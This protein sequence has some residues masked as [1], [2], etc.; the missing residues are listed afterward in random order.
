[1]INELTPL[2]LDAIR[3]V[4]NIG[5]GHAA[6]V[7][8]QLLNQKVSMSVPEV[9]ILPLAEA[10]DVVGGPEKPMVGVY[11]RV[12]GGAPSKILYLF[13]E[14]KALFLAGLLINDQEKC[15][16]LLGELE[17][18]ALKEIGNILTG[19]YVYAFSNFTGIDML[20]SVPALAFDM[21]GAIMNTIL[22]DL[23]EMGDYAL[24]IETQLTACDESVDGHFFLVP[25][26]DSL[27]TILAALGVNDGCLKQSGSECPN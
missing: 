1:M 19:A 3:E 14:E 20:S 6:T 21:V 12:F 8:S 10:C 27:A 25:D 18:S 5:A 7:L 17:V 23:G 24:I 11:L 9:N 15:R 16:N 22:A 4:G 2:Q 13:P 26:P